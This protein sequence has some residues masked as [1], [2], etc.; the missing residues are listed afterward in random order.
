MAK[1]FIKFLF[2]FFFFFISCLTVCSSG[3][4]VGF[5]FDARRNSKSS[6]PAATISFLKKNKVSTSQ[7][8]VFVADHKNL[9]TLSNTRIPV[10]L[11]LNPTEVKNLG[12]SKASAIKWLK[13]HLIT[14][15]P[16]INI[17]SIIV[18]TSSS[19]SVAQ[20]HLPLLIPTLNSIHSAL[21]SLK[22]DH[23]VKISVVFS[24]S[25]LEKL[26][27]QY[28]RDLSRVLHFIQ[29][30]RAFIMVE[31]DMIGELSMG[32]KF[33]GLVIKSATSAA[34]VIH[35]IDV[36]M[37]L[38]I[39]SSAVPSATEVK[40]FTKKMMESLES[41][42][43]IK[44]RFF[45]VFAE[46]SH[47]EESE[48]K[49][50][51]R[52]EQIFH[53]S[54]RELLY[55]NKKK[56]S[57]SK[58]KITLHDTIN[59]LTPI[60]IPTMN[61]TPTIVTVPSTNPVTVM[62]T[63]PAAIPVT[64]PTTNPVVTTPITVPS[65]NPVNPLVP[66]FPVTTPVTV[67][68]TPPMTN[69]VTTYPFPP[70]TNNP[71]TNPVTTA[72]VTTNPPTV[73]GQTWCV[74]KTGVMESALQVAL[75]YACGANAVD[76]LAIQ[77]SGS[78]YNPNTL[79]SHASYAFNSYYQKNPVPMS[80]DFGGAAMLVNINPSTGSCVYPSSS[81]S[82]STPTPTTS[83]PPSS[84]T[85]PTTPPTTNPA[86][87]PITNPTTTGG[88]SYG[89]PP[90]VLNTSYPNSPTDLYGS[91]PPPG[92]STTTS[93]AAGLQPLFV[94]IILVTSFTTAKLMIDL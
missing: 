30:N 8:R 56:K 72:P 53:S 74:A 37:V 46:I 71:V 31:S 45:G 44:D 41:S 59:P 84:T 3:T 48:Q 70:P 94:S 25:V 43:H 80:C 10:D 69:P 54:H 58:T 55:N 16:Y 87:M 17:T 15:H 67:P 24:L 78:C 61:P 40:E 91:Q 47:I 34:T 92:F 38:N 73:S 89:T 39:K 28:K 6:T 86:T 21:K 33:I 18:G 90:A 83:T 49:D 93:I 19:N 11:Y 20:K 36:P 81:S 35:G 76:C 1:G 88:A 4:L 32:D 62:P 82:S 75:D 2:Y 27:K 68:V 51:K 7:I 26:H 13:T 60:T 22:L 12:R 79:Q 63:N 57:I 5:S 85:I 29:K 52:E 14:F 66:G 65:T 50:I 9:I 64:V 77:S 42:S 23:Q